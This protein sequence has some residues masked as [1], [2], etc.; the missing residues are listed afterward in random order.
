MIIVTHE[1]AFA[2]D[3]SSQVIFMDGGCILEQG[4]RR[5]FLKIRK[6]RERSSF[7]LVLLMDEFLNNVFY[8]KVINNTLFIRKT[9]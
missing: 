6:K 8:K 7:C 3:V 5:K 9:Y 1:M 4:T 2:R